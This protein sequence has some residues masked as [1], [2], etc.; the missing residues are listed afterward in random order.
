MWQTKKL[1]RAILRE[2]G[3]GTVSVASGVIPNE[4]ET[5]MLSL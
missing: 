3:T 1:V 5:T 2:Q 4:R